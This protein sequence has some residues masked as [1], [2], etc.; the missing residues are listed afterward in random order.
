MEK[1]INFMDIWN[2]LRTFGIFYDHLVHFFVHL[3]HF[4]RFWYHGPIKIWQPWCH[5]A[6]A[7]S[8][9]IGTFLFFEC[10]RKKSAVTV[11]RDQYY[12]FKKI[13]AKKFSE[14]IGVFDSKQN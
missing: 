11:T 12:D 2:I 4:F 9:R 8:A 3:V 5:V 14:K 10:R 7:K 6:A 1:C 13:F